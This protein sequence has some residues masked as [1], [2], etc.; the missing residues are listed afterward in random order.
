MKSIQKIRIGLSIFTEGAAYL[1]KLARLPDGVRQNEADRNMVQWGQDSLDKLKI[2]VKI[3]GQLAPGPVVL[4]GNHVSYLEVPLLLSQGPV[5]FMAKSEIGNWPVIG[6][7]IRDCGMMLVKRDSKGHRGDAKKIAVEHLKKEPIHL[8]LF[9]SGTTS[10]QE[11]KPWRWGPFEIAATA[12]VP[13][14]P[15]RFKFTPTRE[16]A[17]IDDDAFI[18]HLWRLLD[19]DTIQAELEFHSPVMV[20]DVAKD[21]EYWHRWCQEF[22]I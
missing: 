16:T 3:K 6:R 17:F 15:I 18:P 1:R 20:K 22:L 14:Q 5:R 2:Q 4:I 19:L 8:V 11:T 12:G 7:A 13:I 10:I 9:P 21:C